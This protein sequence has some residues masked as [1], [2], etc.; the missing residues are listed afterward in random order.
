MVEFDKVPDQLL[1]TGIAV[2]QN[3]VVVGDRHSHADDGA[4]AAGIYQI[5]NMVHCIDVVNR[6]KNED[7][8]VQIFIC[9]QLVKL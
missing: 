7:N 8:T 9:R 6:I 3:I 4:F 5:Q 2:N 1:H